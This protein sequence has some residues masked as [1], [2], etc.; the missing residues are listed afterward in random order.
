MRSLLSAYSCVIIANRPTNGTDSRASDVVALA[1]VARPAPTDGDGDGAAAAPP[2][3]DMPLRKL[4]GFERFADVQP[5]EQRTA[6]FASNAE[7]L[8]VVG[9]DGSKWLHPGRY[10]IECGSVAAPAVRELVLV[11][12]GKVRQ[13]SSLLKAVITAFPFVSLPFLAVPLRS[14]R[15]LVAI[16]GKV[17]VDANEWAAKAA[18]AAEAE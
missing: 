15:T 11:G 3:P 2:T 8:G 4:F 12:A 6:Y 18:G 5:G 9:T 14:Q 1:F 7:S 10:R 17:L 13:W 16:A